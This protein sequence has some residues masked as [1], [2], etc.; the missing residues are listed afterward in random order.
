VIN[1][2]Y[3]TCRADV[4]HDSF[5]DRSELKS[6]IMT[7][8]QEHLAEASAENAKIFHH[9][10]TDSDGKMS[11]CVCG[12][13]ATSV[14]TG[15]CALAWRDGVKNERLMFDAVAFVYNTGGLL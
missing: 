6:W 13:F 1:I 12:V 15:I 14:L 4:N 9:L 7:K 5:L 3:D 2:V 8:V 10:D 11:Y